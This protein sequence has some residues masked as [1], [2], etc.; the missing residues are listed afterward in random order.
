MPKWPKNRQD[1]SQINRESE[2]LIDRDPE[3]H[4]IVNSDFQKR[5]TDWGRGP[6]VFPEPTAKRHEN[7]N[8][9]EARDGFWSHPSR[10]TDVEG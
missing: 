4:I 6:D 2:Y 1:L 3:H 9:C 8:S 5:G 7:L 10:P